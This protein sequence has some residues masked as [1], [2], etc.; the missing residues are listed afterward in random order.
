MISPDKKSIRVTL[1]NEVYLLLND[2]AKKSGATKSSI[3]ETMILSFIE[4]NVI[5]NKQKQI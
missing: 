3:I 5:D 2:I 4:S 1:S